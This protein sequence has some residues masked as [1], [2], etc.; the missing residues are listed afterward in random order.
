ML[1]GLK[2][3]LSGGFVIYGICHIATVLGK[4]YLTKVSKTLDK[5]KVESLSKMMS[6]DIIINMHQ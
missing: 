2:I 1:E 5:S 3:L 4:C 6:K